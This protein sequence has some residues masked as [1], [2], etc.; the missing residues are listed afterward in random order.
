MQENYG[1][2]IKLYDF[3]RYTHSKVYIFDEKIAMIGSVNLDD[4]SLENNYEIAFSCDDPRFV[5]QLVQMFNDDIKKTKQTLPLVD[6]GE[7]E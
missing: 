4:N 5:S 7:V 2:N 1:N 3:P 6:A